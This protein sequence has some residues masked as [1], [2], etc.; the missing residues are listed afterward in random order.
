MHARSLTKDHDVYTV[1]RA[2]VEGLELHSTH[3][4]Q[5][6]PPGFTA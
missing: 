3:K 2:D 4:Q 6:K 5:F 1:I